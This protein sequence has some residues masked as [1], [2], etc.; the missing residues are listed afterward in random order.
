M[1]MHLRDQW[2]AKEIWKK[3]VT[4]SRGRH[5]RKNIY[6]RG[7]SVLRRDL[8]ILRLP[9]TRVGKGFTHN[10]RSKQWLADGQSWNKGWEESGEYQKQ[11]SKIFCW[12]PKYLFLRWREWVKADTRPAVSPEMPTYQFSSKTYCNGIFPKYI[13]LPP[14]SPNN[15]F[16]FNPYKSKQGN[17]ERIFINH[18]GIIKFVVAKIN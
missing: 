16:P 1:W 10:S 7:M 14:P 4:A 5:F 6:P 17:S 15:H 8:S 18:G 3:G 13:L 11:R 9:E 2:N 12:D